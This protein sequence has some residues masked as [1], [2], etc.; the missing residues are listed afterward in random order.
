MRAT[1]Y[2]GTA[3]RN[4]NNLPSLI[5]ENIFAGEEA[6]TLKWKNRVS[7]IIS[8]TSLLLPEWATIKPVEG[9]RRGVHTE[10]LQPLLNEMGEV[11]RT[12]TT[13]QW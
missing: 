7:E 13:T 2:L 10:H 5:Q 8:G 4:Q 3:R 12:D 9:G 11:F 1:E 6:L